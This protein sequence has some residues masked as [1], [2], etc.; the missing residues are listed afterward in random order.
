MAR[1]AKALQGS[2][3]FA[4]AQALSVEAVRTQLD[5]AMDRY[6]EGDDAG[7]EELY[8]LAAAR[9]HRLLLRLSGN[10]ALADDLMQETFLRVHRA[11]GTFA[12]GAA[13][14]PWIY[15]IANNTF[16]DWARRP[17]ARRPPVSAD[18]VEGD[19]ALVASPGTRGDEALQGQ[20]TMA[21]V[22]SALLA[23][24]LRQREAFILVR[25]EGLSAREAADVLGTT[26]GALRVLACRA[27]EALRAA[28]ERAGLGGQS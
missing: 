10:R 21:I 22:Q 6:A 26:E 15:A 9:I 7:F 1:R 14:L 3:D 16:R 18:A 2:A 20:Q 23:L 28:L 17:D 5:R 25:F 8:G 13:A 19:S 4:A 27:Y 11:R 24:P 12:R